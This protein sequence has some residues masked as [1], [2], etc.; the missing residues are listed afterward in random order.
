[1]K[2]AKEKLGHFFG[3]VEE[4]VVAEADAGIAFLQDFSL[5]FDRRKSVRCFL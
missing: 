4:A 3:T 1:L 5:F 2:K